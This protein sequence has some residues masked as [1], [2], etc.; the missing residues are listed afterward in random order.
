MYSRMDGIHAKF[1]LL[2]EAHNKCILQAGSNV[3]LL[4]KKKIFYGIDE[5][6][7]LNDSEGVEVPPVRVSLSPDATDHDQLSSVDSVSNS[8]SMGIDLYIHVLQ[9]V[10]GT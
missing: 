1:V 3:L 7:A 10:N 6:A 9:I 2:V 4:M 5:E 8:T